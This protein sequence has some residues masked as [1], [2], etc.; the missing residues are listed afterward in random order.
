MSN[1]RS[2]LR[3][4]PREN[5]NESK[6]SVDSKLPEKSLPHLL[7]ERIDGQVTTVDQMFGCTAQRLHEFSLAGDGRRLP[8]GPA[9]GDGGGESRRNGAQERILS[10]RE[11]ASLWAGSVLI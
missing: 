3:G 9:Q 2:A 7:L 1:I 4:A 6:V 5:P 10:N 8:D 11:K